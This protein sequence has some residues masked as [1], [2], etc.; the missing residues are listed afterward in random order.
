[1]DYGN[2]PN[3]S[4]VNFKVSQEFD[5]ERRPTDEADHETLNSM[6]WDEGF[7]LLYEE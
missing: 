6:E 1:M 7:K 2:Y 4:A 3:Q 5:E